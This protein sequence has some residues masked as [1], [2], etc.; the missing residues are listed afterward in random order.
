[1][2]LCSKGFFS[3]GNYYLKINYL[4]RRRMLYKKNLEAFL[5]NNETSSDNIENMTTDDIIAAASIVTVCKF[6]YFFNGFLAVLIVN[7]N[8]YLI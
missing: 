8:K 5:K 4:R 1:M 7:N 3:T 2:V 6:A